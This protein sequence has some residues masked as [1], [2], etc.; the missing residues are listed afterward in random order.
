MKKNEFV[1]TITEFE[2]VEGNKYKQRQVPT[3]MK[4][5]FHLIART[6]NI[7]NL[8]TNDLTSHP[9]FSDKCLQMKVAWSKNVRDK[10]ECPP[11]IMIG[12]MDPFFCVLV[13][14]ACHLECGFSD[15]EQGKFLFGQPGCNDNGGLLSI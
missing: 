14:L 10:R 8:E 5:H 11:Q 1:G 13:A 12:A 4:T 6:N 9:H 2:A 7:C 3:M 15:H